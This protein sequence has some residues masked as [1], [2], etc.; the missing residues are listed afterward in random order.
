MYVYYKVT[1]W[2][3][4]PTAFR[5]LMAAKDNSTDDF[6]FSM[7]RLIYSVGEPLNP[8][9]IRWGMRCFNLPIHDNWWMTETGMQLIANYPSM[10]VRLGSMGKPFPGIE[11]AIVNDEG[12]EV[13]PNQIGNLAIKAGWPSMMRSIWRNKEKYETYFEN[14]PWYISGDSAHMDEDGYFWFHGRIDD[15]I[16]SAGERIGPFEV[17][18]RLV[19][20]P[21]IAEAGVIGKPDD[22]RGEIVKAFV[23]LRDG[24]EPSDELKKEITDFVKLGLAAHAKPRE[25]E[26]IDVLP[27]TRSGKIMRRVLKAKELGLPTGDLSTME[28][29]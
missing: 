20:H 23:K 19:E 12:K 13:P 9:V 27:K 16:M 22:L 25:I 4:A 6:D 21:A 3:S 29:A 8:E 18:S 1:I 11:A 14:K 17:E 5:L 2:Y 10:S 15:V 26:F 28:E 7:L 24:Y